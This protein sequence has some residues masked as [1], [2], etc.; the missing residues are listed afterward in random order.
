MLASRG[1]WH[2]FLFAPIVMGL[3]YTAASH[4]SS[5][6]EGINKF[7]TIPAPISLRPPLSSA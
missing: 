1:A 3:T 5:D 6:N 2:Y 4:H 7:H